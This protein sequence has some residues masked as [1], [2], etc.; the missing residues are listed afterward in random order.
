[1]ADIPTPAGLYQLDNVSDAAIAANALR[2]DSA[3]ADIPA[4]E[5]VAQPS[6]APLSEG[7]LTFICQYCVF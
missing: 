2:R 3:A 1:M 7:M 6:T 5:A 4:H